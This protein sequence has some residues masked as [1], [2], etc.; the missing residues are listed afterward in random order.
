MHFS[1]I[2]QNQYQL[3]V[4]KIIFGV[5]LKSSKIV[6]QLENISRYVGIFNFENLAEIQTEN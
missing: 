6:F 4:V 2:F 5:A 3:G 1:A